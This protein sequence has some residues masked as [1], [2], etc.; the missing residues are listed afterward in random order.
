[1][2]SDSTPDVLG[3]VLTFMYR[4]DIPES[5]RKSLVSNPSAHFPLNQE[6]PLTD[7]FLTTVKGKP[8]PVE[9][10]DGTTTITD[11]VTNKEKWAIMLKKQAELK[12]PTIWSPVKTTPKSSPMWMCTWSQ[13]SWTSCR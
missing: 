9:L 12:I 11:T 8:A 6:F 10:N 7:K 4:G 1:M 3:K 13:R 2:L 5:Y